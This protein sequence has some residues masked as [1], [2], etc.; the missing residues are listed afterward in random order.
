MAVGGLRQPPPSITRHLFALI[1]KRQVWH[2]FNGYHQARGVK[3][4]DLPVPD[5]LDLVHY[6]ILTLTPE[7]KVVEANRTLSAAPTTTEDTTPAPKAYRPAWF[8]SDEDASNSSFAAAMALGANRTRT[9]AGEGT[10]P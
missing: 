7:D 4:L 2:R 10:R 1:E 3:A 8:G 5:F 9:K 6:W